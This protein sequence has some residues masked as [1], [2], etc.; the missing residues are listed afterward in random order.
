MTDGRTLPFLPWCLI[1]GGDWLVVGHLLGVQVLMMQP[2][3]LLGPVV[4]STGLFVCIFCTVLF[5]FL[6]CVSH[7]KYHS[8]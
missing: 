4:S 3:L 8:L 1:D 6:C 2:V 7:M 5:Y